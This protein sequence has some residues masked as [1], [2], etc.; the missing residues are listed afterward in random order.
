MTISDGLQDAWRRDLRALR[1]DLV[2]AQEQTAREIARAQEQTLNA[3]L[4]ST[5]LIDVQ[6]ARIDALNA[7]IGDL[8]GEVR[9]HATEEATHRRRI[10]TLLERVA[11]IPATETR[12]VRFIAWLAT[13]LAM[14]PASARLLVAVGVTAMLSS[15]LGITCAGARSLHTRAV[16]DAPRIGG[17]YP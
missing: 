16:E 7:A 13:G 15:G 4:A 2:E 12:F 5:R 14:R 17:I 9:A 6:A 10:L 1:G 8:A 11:E 3:H